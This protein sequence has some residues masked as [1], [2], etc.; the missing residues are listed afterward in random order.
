MFLVGNLCFATGWGAS[1]V[2]FKKGKNVYKFP[3]VLQVLRMTILDG[4]TCENKYFPGEVSPHEFCAETKALGKSA[5]NV[6]K[7]L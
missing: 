7:K 6:S 1:E 4:K 5:C 3:D 2:K